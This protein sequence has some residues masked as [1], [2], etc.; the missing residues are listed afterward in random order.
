MVVISS[1]VK[2]VRKL[3]DTLTMNAFHHLGCHTNCRCPI[4]AI[5]QQDIILSTP[6]YSDLT[7]DHRWFLGR[8]QYVALVTVVPFNM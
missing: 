2:Q 4:I 6:Q 1:N 3:K 5:L 8:S 7:A